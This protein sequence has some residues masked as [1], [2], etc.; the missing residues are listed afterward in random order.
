MIPIKRLNS[1][2]GHKEIFENLLFPNKYILSKTESRN[3]RSILYYIMLY[4][5]I[6]NY[7]ILY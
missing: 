7:I 5:V 6:L 4:Y 3:G 1:Y 2:I